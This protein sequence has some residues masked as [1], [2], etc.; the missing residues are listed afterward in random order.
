MSLHIP[1]LYELVPVYTKD[2]MPA[3]HVARFCRLQPG[4]VFLPA[5]SSVEQ[6][7]T[8]IQKDEDDA[9]FD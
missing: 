7:I 6:A 3:G 2:G 9:R 1:P 4:E 5:G 8:L